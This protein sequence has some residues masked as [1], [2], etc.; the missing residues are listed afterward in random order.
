MKCPNCGIE[1]L[2]DSSFCMECGEK[3]SIVNYSNSQLNEQIITPGE[4][5]LQD[6][7]NSSPKNIACKMCGVENST[8]D[9]FCKMCGAKIVV[10]PAVSDIICSHCGSDVPGENSFCPACGFRIKSPRK[11]TPPGGVPAIKTDVAPPAPAPAPLPPIENPVPPTKPQ[12][13][14][15]YAGNEPN[16]SPQNPYAP[17]APLP[18]QNQ[19]PEPVKPPPPGPQ[20]TIEQPVSKIIGRSLS[21]LKGERAGE[22]FPFTQTLTLGRYAG[23]IVFPND[24]FLNSRHLAIETTEKGVYLKDLKSRNGVYY[25]ISGDQE[26]GFGTKFYIGDYLFSFE[27]V[28]SAEWSLNGIWELGV[29]LM[30]S[31]RSEKPWGRINFY[32]PQGTI[33]GSY[34]LWNDEE[35]IDFRFLPQNK[36]NFKNSCKIIKVKDQMTI[37]PVEGEAYIQLVNESEF[38][39]PIRFMIG[40]EIL[41]IKSS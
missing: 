27:E 10:Q 14:K 5:S 23:E 2:S 26:I 22:Y 12:S 6:G 38:S 21:V 30:G 16:I 28:S 29:R 39:L 1:N 13:A 35:I 15:S 31:M 40:R 17:A 36:D 3:I 19:A 9:Q 34:P 18:P 25:L 33:G 24:E 11:H 41:E 8:S 7:G 32:S 20:N 4:R 37:S